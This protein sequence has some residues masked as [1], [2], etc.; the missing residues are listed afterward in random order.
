MKR[1]SFEKLYHDGRTELCQGRTN[2]GI[3][4]GLSAFIGIWRTYLMDDNHL[5]NGKHDGVG[6]RVLISFKPCSFVIVSGIIASRH[7]AHMT[8]GKERKARG[9][10][11]HFVF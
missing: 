7:F 8:T 3:T 11:V 10:T 1:I 4:F 6:E 2:Q 5:E 9:S